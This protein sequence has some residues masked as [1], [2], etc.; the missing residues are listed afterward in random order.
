MW[1]PFTMQDGQLLPV[2]GAAPVSDPRGALPDDY[3]A[4][5]LAL[6][7]ATTVFAAEGLDSIQ[8]ATRWFHAFLTNTEPAEEKA[9]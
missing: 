7:Y 2:E 6:R 1:F 9:D 5:E 8:L 3:A 4:R